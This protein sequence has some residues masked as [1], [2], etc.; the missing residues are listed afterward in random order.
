MNVVSLGHD[1]GSKSGPRPLCEDDIR[2]HLAHH[3]D[4]QAF[5]ASD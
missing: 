4:A 3:V 2:E 5:L 1:Q